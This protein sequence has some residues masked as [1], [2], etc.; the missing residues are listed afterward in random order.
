M[1]ETEKRWEGV[2]TDEPVEVLVTAYGTMA[3]ICRTTIERLRDEGH[4]VSMLRPITLYPFPTEA[5]RAAADNARQVISIEMSMGQMVEDVQL[6]VQ[7]T[8]P[9]HFYGKAGGLVPS[10]E[11]VRE[12]ILKLIES[13]E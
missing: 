7:G 13:P 4:K 6:A 12:A 2:Y 8:V 11:D 9:V 3:R 10:P 1:T 5:V